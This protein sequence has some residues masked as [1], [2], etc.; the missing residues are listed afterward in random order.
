[1]L[2]VVRDHASAQDEPMPEWRAK[3]ARRAFPLQALHGQTE[4]IAYRTAQ[5]AAG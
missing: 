1:M 5:Q 2:G 3:Q 4:R